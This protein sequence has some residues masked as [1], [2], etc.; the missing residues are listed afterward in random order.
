MYL[1]TLMFFLRRFTWWVVLGMT[2]KV[3]I[4]KLICKGNN[5][6]RV[7]GADFVKTVMVE[8]G[9]GFNSHELH[10]FSFVLLKYKKN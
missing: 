5:A 2:V 8:G 1:S 9:S 4:S 6:W 10:K 3:F 7:G